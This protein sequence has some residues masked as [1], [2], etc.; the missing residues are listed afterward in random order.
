MP[1]INPDTVV[2]TLAAQFMAITAL[3]LL[4]TQII[5]IYEGVL[6][7]QGQIGLPMATAAIAIITNCVLNYGL[8]FGKWGLPELGVLG[9]AWGTMIARSVQLML[10][11]AW[12]YARPSGFN[13]AFQYLLLACQPQR[14]KAFLTFS[15]PLMA[16]YT[17]WAV[18][19]TCY[20]TLTGFAGTQALRPWL[21]WYLSRAGFALFVGLANA[22]AVLVGRSL[23]ADGF[24]QAWYLHRYFEQTHPVFTAGIV[25]KL[26]AAAL[27][28]TCLVC[29][30]CRCCI[31]S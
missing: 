16:N 6:R 10:V 30:R 12:I 14:L 7:A 31:S 18:G 9:A 26:M 22:S 21:S 15:A 23:G 13:L 8:I 2:C 20:H 29:T 17:I 24:N 25:Y 5:V 27:A 1:L 11:L 4:F 19:N 3:A 28:F